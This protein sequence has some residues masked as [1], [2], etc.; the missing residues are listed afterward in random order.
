MRVTVTGPPSAGL[1]TSARA[2]S[3]ARSTHAPTGIPA[4]S[5][6]AVIAS[7]VRSLTP[8]IAQ[9]LANPVPHARVGR[10]GRGRTAGR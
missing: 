9:P 2:S 7:R 1:G 10:H 4:S 3:K 6:A 8:L 5:A